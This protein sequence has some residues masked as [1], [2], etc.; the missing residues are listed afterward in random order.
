MDKAEEK[1]NH[2]KET[3]LEDLKEYFRP[4]FLNRI[5][6]IVVF[7]ALTH[8][9]IK[10]I[11]KIQI[12][13]LQERI[14]DKKITVALTPEALESLAK[15]S[16]DR[17]FGARLVRRKVQELVEDPLTTRY[18]EGEYKEG[19]AIQ[20]VQKGET[21]DLKRMQ[22]DLVKAESSKPEKAVKKV[23]KSAKTTE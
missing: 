8:E 5:D 17:Q 19:D 18:L 21:V 16:Y 23:R 15:I 11:V 10:E 14:K 7:N 9:M 6:K 13:F 20:I 4:E 22:F 1:Y 12:S 2:A 3:I